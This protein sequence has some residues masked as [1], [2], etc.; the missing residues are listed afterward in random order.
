MRSFRETIGSSESGLVATGSGLTEIYLGEN[1]KPRFSWIDDDPVAIALGSDT[2]LRDLLKLRGQ[3]RKFMIQ[4]RFSTVATSNAILALFMILTVTVACGFRKPWRNYDKQPFDSQKW[5]T[6]DA[7]T[8]G[9]MYFD[10]FIKRTLTGKTE[11]DVL[12][13]LGEPDTKKTI[14][15]L[16]VWLYRIE[17]VGEWNRPAFPVSFDKRGRAFAG[18]VKDGTMS[19]IIEE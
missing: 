19:M 13:L 3:Q 9:T 10:L 4:R 7:Q 18:S 15:G 11:D 14:E 5:K 6:G 1:A 12:E 8:R 17:I 2:E 16:N